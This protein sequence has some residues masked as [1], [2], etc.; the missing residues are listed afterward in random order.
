MSTQLLA[1]HNVVPQD[2]VSQ[3]LS[4]RFM[5]HVI[6]ACEESPQK[7]CS[8]VDRVYSRSGIEKR[9][10]VIPD[11]LVEDPAEFRFFP[12]AWNLE[13]FPS[14]AQRM[15]VYEET[16]LELAYQA[17]HQALE[18]A[19]VAAAEVTHLVICTC[20]GFFAPGLDILLGQKLGLAPT[21]TRCILGFMGCY[22][23][24]SGLRTADQIVRSHDD[25]VVLQVC[26]ELC[27]LHFQKRPLRDLLIANSLFADGC[28]AALYGSQRRKGL[29][30][31]CATHSVVEQDSLE[32]MS[33]RIGDH[34]FEMR[35]DPG[36]PGMLKTLIVPFLEDL[37]AKSGVQREEIRGWALHPGGR[38]IVE[39]LRDVLGLQNADVQESFQVLAEYGN[40][41]S[42][43]IFFVLEKHLGE[44][45]AAPTVALGFGPGL[46]IEGALFEI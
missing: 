28:S 25:A 45:R 17:A 42:A 40:M 15:Q 23:G 14:T 31:L 7:L 39:E 18:N 20:T 37:L 46:T 35:M 27:S 41:S 3:E 6:E 38:K 2:S 9:H 8:F 33:W 19:G 21:V 43:T 12:R 26:V 44:R 16:S 34:G 11:F 36:I 32:Q 13:P 5:C 1:L 24:F 22:A 4:A 29:A 10:T 30:R